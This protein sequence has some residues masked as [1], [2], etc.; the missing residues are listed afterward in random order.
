MTI[1]QEKLLSLLRAHEWNDIEFKE[2][3]KGVPRDS[4]ESVSAFANTKGGHLVF[5][6]QKKETQFN[7]VGIQEVDQIQNDFLTTVRQKD[8][9]NVELNIKESLH[10]ID[11]QD[12]LVFYIPEAARKDKPV[13]LNNTPNRAFIRKGACDVKCT[14]AELMRFVNDA[15]I[16]RFD[17]QPLDLDPSK[18]F[19]AKDID[20]YRKQY[21]KKEGNR[22]YEEADSLE[23]LFQL[24]LLRDTKKGR[25]PTIASIL[26]FGTDGYLRDILPRPVIDCQRYGFKS[27]AY[28][29]GERWLDRTLCDYNLIQS[30]RSVLEWYWKFAEIPFEVDPKTMQRKDTPPD[31]IAFREAIINM[32]IH[33]DYTDH[34]RKAE[35]LHFTDLT[36]F[37]NPGDAFTDVDDLLAPGAKEV[38]NPRIVTAFRR[39]GFSENAGWGLQDVFKNWRELGNIPPQIINNKAAKT[40]ELIL[41]KELLLSTD[42]LEFQT[43]VGV[44]LSKDEAAVFALA[45]KQKEITLLDVR[46]ISGKSFN[47]SQKIAD[48]LITQVLLSETTPGRFSLSSAMDERFKNY[49]G[50]ALDNKGAHDEAHDE[51]HDHLTETELQ[52]LKFS[53]A[54]KSTQELL[55]L[56]GYRSRTGNYKAALYNLLSKNY[57]EMT[58]PE[59][60]RSK[61]QKYRL[62]Q[63]GKHLIEKRNIDTQI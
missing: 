2:A 17:G 14:P 6:I 39:I 27:D 30:L 31:Y 25:K 46:N 12:I 8:K 10:T 34:S 15:S 55:K 3:K 44:H 5:G 18:C 47:D 11:G 33:Q 54:P 40:F 36:K 28:A 58:I 56:L 1:S 21:E 62:T 23:F 29:S 37:W 42:Q 52:I 57:I 49:D 26:L 24:G 19:D 13:F 50:P 32:L 35:I 59:R 60:P 38:R 16:D 61:N 53:I 7:L 43:S 63:T 41:Q 4:Y 51:A 22:S 45:C 9:I 20:W 48:K